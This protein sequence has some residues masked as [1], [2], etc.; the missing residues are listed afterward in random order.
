MTG[1][2]IGPFKTGIAHSVL[3]S[4]RSAFLDRR[5]S[6][7]DPLSSLRGCLKLGRGSEA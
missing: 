5:L 7:N 3:L 4:L 2:E 6:H 1:Q